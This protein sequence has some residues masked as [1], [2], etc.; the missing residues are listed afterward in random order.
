MPPQ[1]PENRLA[2]PGL[3]L[4]SMLCIQLGTAL[5]VP[6]MERHGSFG[7]TALRLVCAALV[8]LPLARPDFTAFTRRQWLAALGLGASMALM[9]LSY[10]EA[11]TRIPIGPAITIDFL[12]PLGVAVAA[13]RGWA[14]L[15]L[16]L[17][18]GLGVLAICFGSGGWLFDPVGVL[19]A[20]AAAGGWA[21]YIVLTRPVG[22][23]FAEQAG[24]ALSFVAAAVVALPLAFAVAPSEISLALLPAAAGLAVLTPLVPFSLEMMALR[25]MNIGAF[26]ILM[27]LEPAC[28]GIFGY[29]ILGQLLDAQQ[30]IGI[31]A[32]MIASVG[33]IYI[34]S[35]S[36][37]D[38][39]V[40]EVLPGAA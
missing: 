25:R 24:L 6:V 17:L 5:A 20:L 36:T 1:A 30:I 29:L 28:G 32:V 37:P 10:F 12:G 35:Q 23:L 19:F 2:G 15:G 38:D 40:A 7:V 22:R 18:A 39:A 13:L 8:M 33:A 9:T 27:S 11:V 14:R 3:A 21:G 31:L 4:A 16:P 34:T 26:S